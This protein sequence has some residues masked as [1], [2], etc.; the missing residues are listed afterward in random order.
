MDF[1]RCKLNRLNTQ[2]ALLLGLD[3]RKI[4][5][6]IIPGILPVTN[7]GTLKRFADLTNVHV[8]SWMNKMYDGLENDAT[9]RSLVGAN[10]AMEQVKVL[11]KEGVKNFHFYTLNRSELS[12]A[13]CHMLGI[14]PE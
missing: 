11:R 10:I 13:I 5:V 6:E 3:E 9:T 2:Y 14:R 7:F 12:Y 1:N 4:D 8:P